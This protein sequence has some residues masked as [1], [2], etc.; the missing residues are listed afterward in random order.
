MADVAQAVVTSVDLLKQEL[1]ADPKQLGYASLI[2]KGEDQS[3]ADVVN[4]V[5]A[6][7]V[8]SPVV[9]SD[10]FAQFDYDELDSLGPAR[11]AVFVSMIQ[12]RAAV[13]QLDVDAVLPA[14]KCP[15]TRAAIPPSTRKGSRAEV[16]FGPGAVVSH[17]DVA[18]ALGRGK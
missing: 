3:L 4:K 13:K 16:L 15:N 1:L 9:L 17:I 10:S 12:S 18:I 2:A 5:G 11:I 6:D 7:D 8:P 14:D